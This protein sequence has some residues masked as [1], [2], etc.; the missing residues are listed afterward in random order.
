M[1]FTNTPKSVLAL[2]EK[3]AAT[4]SKTE[5][6]ALVK[7]GMAL[8]LFVRA[9]TMAYDPFTTF[10]MRNA[11][12]KTPGIA[13]GGNSLAEEG[14]WNILKEL[15]SRELSGHAALA[16][17]Q[18]MVD[19]L[20]ED[21]AELF[22]RIINKDMRAGFTEG[23]INR[24]KP[25]TIAE[26]PY[27]RCSLPP[28]S[29]LDKFNWSEGVIS[30]EKADGMFANVNLYDD[31]T[32][33][34]HSRQGTAFPLDEFAQIASFMK[35]WMP[36]GHQFHGELLVTKCG[37]V[38]P[39]EISNGMLNSVAQGGALEPDHG[40]LLLVWD[41]IPLTVA[42]P[43]GKFEEPYKKRLVALLK[44]IDA[45]K[46]YG[47]NPSVGLVPTRVVKSYADA[48]AHYRE[49]LAQGKE[50]TIIKSPHAIWKDGTSK[51]QVK[52]KLEVDV[53]LR[54]V[55]V[56]PGRPGTKNEGR[57]GSLTCETVCGRLRTDVTIKNEK[58]R[59]AVEAN[60]SAWTNGLMVVRA[61]S[62][63]HPS[64]SS[65]LYSLFLPRFVEDQLRTDKIRADTL[66][67][68]L[69]QFEAAARG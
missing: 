11:P 66:Q 12:H 48:W 63:M 39:R 24:V 16:A 17:V 45:G 36:R 40:L 3:I 62:V 61:N 43:K 26:F 14:P 49:L 59:D 7:Q 69:D 38:L 15:A 58:M 56:V 10:G 1:F 2:I 51:D 67:Q 47:T 44:A 8:P 25:G 20:D 52:L 57:P 28:K 27:M 9:V 34:V 19:F 37:Q 68:V 55:A 5:K 54:I 22:R 4:A 21:S 13:P 32:I 6:E 30:Q 64:E 65:E 31:G 46:E 18:R 35:D 23:T 60:P 33:S 42:Q 50:G 41:M 29:N 53:D